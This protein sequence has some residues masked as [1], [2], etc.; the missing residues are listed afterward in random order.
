MLPAMLLGSRSTPVL[1]AGMLSVVAGCEET[2]DVQLRDTEGRVF[3]AK[4]DEEDN[5]ALTQKSGPQWPGAT[6]F[7][8]ESP[9]RLIGVCSVESPDETTVGSECRALECNKNSECPPIFG[10]KY[11]SCISGLCGDARHE[12]NSRDAVLLCLAGLGVGDSSKGQLDRYALAVNCGSPCT[13]PK[14]CRSLTGQ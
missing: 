12:V 10:M 1:F 4:C 6:H 3:A 13:I 14:M 11:G 9:G 5:C 8:L 7:R 2:L